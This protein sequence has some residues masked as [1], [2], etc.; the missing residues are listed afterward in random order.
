M[1]P[2]RHGADDMLPMLWTDGESVPW[3]PNDILAADAGE[4]SEA[5]CAIAP[6]VVQSGSTLWM[7]ETEQRGWTLAELHFHPRYGFFQEQRRA[8]YDWP[9]EA[10]GAMLSRFAAFD[11][12]D[13]EVSRLTGDFGDWLGARFSC[14]GVS[15]YHIGMHT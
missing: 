7:V 5:A 1:E 10:F 14:V 8:T 13:D 4:A 15:R 11:I 9:R 12:S 2:T 6:F 3:T